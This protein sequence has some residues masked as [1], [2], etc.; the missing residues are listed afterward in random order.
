MSLDHLLLISLVVFFAAF[1]QGSTGVGFALIA[2][3]VVGILQPALLP[4]CVLVLMLP[5]NLYVVWRE[6]TAVDRVGAGWITGGRILGTA[7]GLWVLAA[8]SASHLSLFVGASTI[9]AALVT[10]VMPAFSPGR[11][12]FIA[13]GLVTGVTETATGIGGPPLALVYQHQAAPTMRSTVALCFLVGELVSLVTLMVAGRISASQL[14]AA[15]S[16]LPALVV[17]AVLSRMVHRRVNGGFLRVF[18]QVFAI[19]SGLVLLV[20]A[21]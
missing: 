12:A 3:P 1:V 14:S 11:P 13:A 17:G 15:T 9:A 2:A 8:L 21:F 5:L 7:G 20:R 16:L 6:R 10:L 4:V 18:V 19:V